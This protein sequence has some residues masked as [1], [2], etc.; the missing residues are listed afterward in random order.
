MAK[1]Q[2]ADQCVVIETVEA[3]QIFHGPF[4]NWDTAYDWKYKMVEFAEK[5]GF[6]WTYKIRTLNAPSETYKI[7][8]LNAPSELVS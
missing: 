3:G 7:R 1:R 8:T 5:H 2:K 6:S 4:P